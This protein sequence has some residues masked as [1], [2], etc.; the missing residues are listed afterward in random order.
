MDVFVTGGTGGIGSAVI[1]KLV[2]DGCQIIGLSRSDQSS[3][4]LRRLGAS[5]YPG[6]LRDP[7]TWVERATACDAV[8]HLGATF[9]PDMGKVDRIAMLE[10]KKAARHRKQP[11]KVIYTGGIWLYPPCKAGDMLSEKTPFSPLPAFRF[12]SESIK[13]LSTGT[14]LA[15]S[16]IH[17]ALVCGP[18]FGPIAEMTAAL[19]ASGRFETRASTDTSWPLVEVSD[20]ARLYALVLRQTRFRMSVIGSGIGGVSVDH[21]ASHIS[22]RHGK[23]LEIITQPSPEGIDPDQDWAAG[24]A[25]SQSADNTHAKRLLSWSPE[26]SAVEDLVISLSR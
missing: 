21:L 13:T 14:D 19:K 15:L 10:M 4:K 12:M 7:S 1:K 3:E 2:E 22:A 25:L 20:L 23:P 6:N 17:P 8:V 5:A 18:D 16:V 26:H 11:L 24:Y 9:S